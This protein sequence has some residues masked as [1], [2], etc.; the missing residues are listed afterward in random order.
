MSF[1]SRGLRAANKGQNKS[2]V[3]SVLQKDKNVPRNSRLSKTFS[4]LIS[5]ESDQYL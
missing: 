2:A 3:V 4:G 1:V 5:V